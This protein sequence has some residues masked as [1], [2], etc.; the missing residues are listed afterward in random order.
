MS[1]T[2]Q[3]LQQLNNTNFPNNTTGYITPALLRDFNS[4]SVDSF[5]LQ[6]QFDANSASVDSRLDS[7]ESFSSSLV[8]NFA[9]V[10]QLNASSSTLQSN[11]NGK[12]STGSV[13]T[14]SQSVYVGF[15]DQ[16]T[17][18]TNVSNTFTANETKFNAYTQSNNLAVAGKA[19]LSQ[20]N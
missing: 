9:T 17:I 10:T 7:L 6:S 3:Q 2:K 1:L 20:D 14:L 4:Q 8:T 12:A 13:N 19:S 5:T 15:S 11:I 16:A 18:N